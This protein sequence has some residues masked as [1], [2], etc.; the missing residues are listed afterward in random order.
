MHSQEFLRSVYDTCVYLKNDFDETLGLIILV[1]Y[2]DIILIATT[3]RSDVDKLKAKFNMAEA[4]TMNISLD[5]HFL[6][7]IV[8]CTKDAIEIYFLYLF[9]MEVPWKISCI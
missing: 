1:L 4:K 5:A 6:L 9:T 2:V 3:M 7:S 8:Q